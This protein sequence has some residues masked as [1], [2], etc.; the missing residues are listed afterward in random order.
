MVSFLANRQWTIAALVVFLMLLAGLPSAPNPTRAQE[1][2]WPTIALDPT[3]GPPG[4]A[5]TV[6]GSGWIPGEILDFMFAVNLEADGRYTEDTDFYD[7]GQ[8]TVGDDGSFT[9]TV[10]IPAEAADIGVQ[11][12]IAGGSGATWKTDAVF[13]VID[14][15]ETPPPEGEGKTDLS[16]NAGADQTVPGPSPV[17]VQLDGTGSTGDI[18]RYLWYNQYGLLRAEGATPVIDV[19]FGYNDPQPGTTRT[20]TLVVEDSQGNTAQ[21]DVSI[22]LGETEEEETPPPEAEPTITL[23]PTEGPPGTE[24]TVTGSGWVPGDT[25]SL[26]FAANLENGDYHFL[27]D[28]YH[29]GE[30]AVGDDGS[31]TF[32]F[33]VPTDAKIGDARVGASSADGPWYVDPLF[34]VTEPEEPSCPEPTATVSPSSGRIGDTV[35]VQGAGWLP[36]GTVTITA[37]GPTQF[38]L[39]PLTV[40][41]SGEWG[42]SFTLPELPAAEI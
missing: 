17:A 36:G 21:D 30:T 16:A 10:I 2:D 4:T 7:I 31:F 15:A 3:E 5:V 39:G 32:T 22:T 29:L 8:A 37:T 27:T 26:Q 38:G 12:V 41:D 42:G 19:N 1:S 13:H 25:V 20:F 11:K 33:T 6:T 28:Y 35:T 18:V 9:A 14:P 34:H 24:V 40:P 23:D